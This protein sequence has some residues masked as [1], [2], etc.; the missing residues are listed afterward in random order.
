MI[1]MIQ[2][3]GATNQS[4]GRQ[5]NQVSKL[6]SANPRRPMNRQTAVNIPHSRRTTQR[7][8]CQPP[9]INFV[10]LIMTSVA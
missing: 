1:R 9:R 6:R 2:A 5:I 3:T 8:P 4:S 7:Q 10:S